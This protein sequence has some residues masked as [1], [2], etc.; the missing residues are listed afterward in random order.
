M[1]TC[2]QPELQW[3]PSSDDATCVQASGIYLQSE[4]QIPY[5]SNAAQG[6]VIQVNNFR[7]MCLSVVSMVQ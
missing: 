2:S 1:A 7:V 3:I 4:F 5:V 6:V